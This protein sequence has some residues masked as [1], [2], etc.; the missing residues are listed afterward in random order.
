MKQRDAEQR[1]R[2]QTNSDGTPKMRIESVNFT[3]GGF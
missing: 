2:K 3:S 1:Q